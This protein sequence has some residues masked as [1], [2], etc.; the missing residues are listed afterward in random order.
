MLKTKHF[1]GYCEL[2]ET[3]MVVCATCNNN[4]CNGM[5]GGEPGNWCLDCPDAYQVQDLHFKKLCEVEFAGYGKI[6]SDPFKDLREKS[7]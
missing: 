6:I 1:L 3:E 4:C 5:Y 7:K 2:C